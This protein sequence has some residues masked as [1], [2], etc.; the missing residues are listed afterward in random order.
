MSSIR[1]IPFR[2]IFNNDNDLHPLNMLFILVILEVFYLEISSNND[3]DSLP[4][5]ILFIFLTLEVFHLEISGN[6]N[7]NL[8]PKNILL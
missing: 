2:N 6:D 8:H 5:N 3:N 4:K 1:N 7:N